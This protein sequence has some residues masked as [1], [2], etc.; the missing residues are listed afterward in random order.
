MRYKPGQKE[1]TK[2]KMVKAASLNFRR[3]GFAGIG[4][5]GIAKAANV[6]SGAFYQHFGSKD[7]A[8]N[9]AVN[10]GLDEV[11]KGIPMFEKR[12]GDKWVKAFAA[13]YLGKTHRDNL[14]GGCAI[15][16]LTPEIVRSS[17]QTQKA[18]EEKMLIIIDLIAEGLDGGTLSDRQDRA[19]A[20]LSILIGGLTLS[21]AV[22]SQKTADKIS[23]SIIEAAIAAAG[24][25]Q[26][27]S[28][29]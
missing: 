12:D 25:A 6:T 14:A 26:T 2:E 19:W 20:M 24:K 1:E 4:V 23:A 28:D 27:I 29:Q 3:H 10:A 9:A 11:I 16:S 17:E 5:D 18:F 13:Y 7:G 22:K 21:R 8:F 15:T